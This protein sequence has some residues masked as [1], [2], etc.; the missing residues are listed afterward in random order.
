M[1]YADGFDDGYYG[2]YDVVRV[3]DDNYRRGAQ[4]G[5][6]RRGDEE[7]LAEW[8]AGLIDGPTAAELAPSRTQQGRRWSNYRPPPPPS[9]P[10]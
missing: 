7:L 6:T 4:A 10:A 2:R 9:T 1:S 5:R 3:T 8:Q